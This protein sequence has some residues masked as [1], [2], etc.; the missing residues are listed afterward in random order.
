MTNRLQKKINR[1][2]A[3]ANSPIK[4][5]PVTVENMSVESSDTASILPTPKIVKKKVQKR[6]PEEEVKSPL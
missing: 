4:P 5:Q 2:V 3:G 1:K 6:A